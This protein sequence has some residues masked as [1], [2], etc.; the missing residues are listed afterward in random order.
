MPTLHPFTVAC[1]LSSSGRTVNVRV[2]AVDREDA[3]RKASGDGLLASDATPDAPP[4]DAHAEAVSLIR[5]DLF[6]IHGQIAA[7]R[8]PAEQ[9][10]ACRLI[11]LPRDTICQGIILAI[12]CWFV[13]LLLGGWVL[14]GFTDFSKWSRYD[15]KHAITY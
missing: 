5:E 8:V 4:E 13:I 11:R 6:K 3:M 9:L 10:A 15:G 1:V 12:L 14:W 7:L 2:N